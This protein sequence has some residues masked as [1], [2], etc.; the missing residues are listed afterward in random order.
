LP[1]IK[2]R[3][4]AQVKAPCTVLPLASRI[5]PLLFVHRAALFRL[6]RD[7]LGP[8]RLDLIGGEQIAPWRHLIPAAHH[9]CDKT[10]VL[11]AGDFSLLFYDKATRTMSF[12]LWSEVKRVQSTVTNAPSAP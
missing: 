12:L 11:I 6:S 1:A 3:P 2:H 10:I 5:S 4:T 8:Q 9:R 7:H